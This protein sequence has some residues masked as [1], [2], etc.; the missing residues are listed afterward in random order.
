MENKLCKQLANGKDR[1]GF[2]AYFDCDRPVKYKVSY[3][4]VNNKFE[5]HCVCGVHKNS[6]VKWSERVKKRLNY[7]CKLKIEPITSA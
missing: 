4:G 7:D 5:E 6:T 2:M 1:M 3:Y